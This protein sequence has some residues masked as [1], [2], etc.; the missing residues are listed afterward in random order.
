MDWLGYLVSGGIA[1]SVVQV[2]RVAIDWRRGLKADER[3]AKTVTVAAQSA[4]TT[5]FAEFTDDLREQ[6]TE[7]RRRL[8]ALTARMDILEG[9]YR[10]LYD[11]AAGLRQDIYD[12]KPPPPRAWPEGI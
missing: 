9:R 8:D 3:E 10:T 6:L 4:A 2:A 7:E 1:A 11:F 12:Q 5:G